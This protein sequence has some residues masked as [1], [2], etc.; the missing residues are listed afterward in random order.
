MYIYYRRWSTE[1]GRSTGK[2]L[3]TP[4]GVRGSIGLSKVRPEAA[5][6]EASCCCAPHAAPLCCSWTHTHTRATAVHPLYVRDWT[7]TTKGTKQTQTTFSS[8][9]SF[10][11]PLISLTSILL[12][13][14]L[15]VFYSVTIKQTNEASSHCFAQPLCFI[16]R[17]HEQPIAS[18]NG[19]GI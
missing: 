13:S 6:K 5:P 17:K 19:V 18:S 1:A 4:I 3:R 2:K 11:L 16:L 14:H 15:L 7:T 10:C 8:V 9:P 12:H